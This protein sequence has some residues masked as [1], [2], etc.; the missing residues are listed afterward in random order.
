MTRS[1]RSTTLLPHSARDG[2]LTMRAR[3][4]MKVRVSPRSSGAMLGVVRAGVYELLQ[5]TSRRYGRWEAVHL[6][7]G[8]VVSLYADEFTLVPPRKAK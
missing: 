2:L 6:T 3:K 1:E 4:G 7:T 8:S 5:Q